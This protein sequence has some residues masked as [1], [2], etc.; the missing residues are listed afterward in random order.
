M[1]QD[2]IDGV[3]SLEWGSDTATIFYTV[4]D[5]LRRPHRIYRRRV[6]AQP[7]RRAA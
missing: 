3:V 2:R 7:V 5:H 4:P 1:R 6:A